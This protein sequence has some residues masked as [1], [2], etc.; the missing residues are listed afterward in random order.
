MDLDAVR[1]YLQTR[2][3]LVAS[4]LFGSRAE[5]VARPDSDVDIALLFKRAL[6]RQALWD[7]RLEIGAALSRLCRC[8]VDVVPLNEAPVLLCFQ[9]L[10]HGRLLTDQQPSARAEFE[11]RALSRYYDAGRY[12]A[13]RSE[14]L[15]RRILEEGIGGGYRGRRDPLE[16]ARRLSARLAA[17]PADPAA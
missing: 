5:G 11:V 6:D 8:A 9:V 13:F 4:Y 10:R 14:E 12:R 2:G 7:A 3:D 17:L 1:A 16:Q 15:R